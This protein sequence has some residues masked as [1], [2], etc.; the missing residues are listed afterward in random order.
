MEILEN[1][2]IIC[3]S[4]THWPNYSIRACESN[5]EA[6]HL[7]DIAYKHTVGSLHFEACVIIYNYQGTN[8]LLI[9]LSLCGSKF[10]RILGALA[11]IFL[12]QIQKS[13]CKCAC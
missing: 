13:S 2:L 9:F 11:D 4:I 10:R 1:I 8:K 12:S 3:F 7:A 5:Q 6:V